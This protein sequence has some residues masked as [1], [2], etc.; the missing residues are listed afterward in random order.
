MSKNSEE[1]WEVW[2]A[3]LA[4]KLD[5][6][7]SFPDCISSVD[8]ASKFANYFN[9]IYQELDSQDKA[10][11]QLNCDISVY[12]ATD[13]SFC[14]HITVQQIGSCRRELHLQKAY[15]PDDLAGEH[16]LYV[17]PSLIIHLKLLLV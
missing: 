1:F 15:G 6:R 7:V 5:S 8:I 16:L 12:N 2:H 17:L 14:S 4:Q 9:N 11:N 3:K 13:Y 10:D